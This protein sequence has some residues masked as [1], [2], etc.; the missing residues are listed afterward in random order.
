MEMIVEICEPNVP[1]LT[2]VQ[3]QISDLMQ[4][5]NT[6]FQIALK[7]HMGMK[8]LRDEIFEIRKREAI[9][10]RGKMIDESIKVKIVDMWKNQGI[11]QAEIIRQLGVA[12]STVSRT[13][14]EYNRKG[15]HN[16][17]KKSQINEEF[18]QAVDQMIAEAEE[19]SA[20]AEHVAEVREQF[21][22]TLQKLP[23]VIWNALDD[24]VH[25]LNLEI[26]AREQRI[27]EL[28]EELVELE[29]KRYA[30]EQWMEEHT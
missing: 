4:D 15:M 17:E 10:S 24:Q 13:I 29:D 5:G 11:S 27:A 2:P 7:V 6:L 16:P 25:A 22:E 8:K 30:I 28:K 12:S 26:E 23:E 21:V 18:E 3:K 9:M 14:M 1:V 19:K 20:D